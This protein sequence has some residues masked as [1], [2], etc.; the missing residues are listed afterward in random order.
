M[1]IYL[2]TQDLVTGYDTY[3]SMI[4]A[5]ESE[6]EAVK[7]HPDYD[8]DLE[9]F[10]AVKDYPTWPSYNDIDKIIVIFIGVAAENIKKGV[11]LASFNA[12]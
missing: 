6:E 9:R 7:I 8:L 11:I 3:D 10:K 1:N 4:V 12:G 5:A 2:L